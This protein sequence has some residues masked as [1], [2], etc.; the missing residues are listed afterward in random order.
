VSAFPGRRSPALASFFSI[1]AILVNVTAPLGVSNLVRAAEL[2]P[3]GATILCSA[4]GPIAVDAN[5]LPLR[6]PAPLCAFCVPLGALGLPD[7]TGSVLAWENRIVG[8][9]VFGEQAYLRQPS[10]RP[11]APFARGPPFA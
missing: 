6:H 3:V 9:A 5:G 10:R 11:A 7:L 1:L 8:E 2:A 4:A